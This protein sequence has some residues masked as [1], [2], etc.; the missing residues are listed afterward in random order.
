MGNSKIFKAAALLS[1]CFVLTSPLNSFADLPR[2]AA[3]YYPATEAFNITPSF[4][5]YSSS[6]GIDNADIRSQDHNFAINMEYGVNSYLSVG[7]KLAYGENTITTTQY[8]SSYET[9]VN[10]KGMMDPELYLGSRYNFEKFRI[11]GN[12]IGHASV[13]SRQI[14]TTDETGNMANG[15]ASADAELAVDAPLGPIT[16]GALFGKTIWNDYRQVFD[17]N[18]NTKHQERGA[19]FEKYK[20]YFEMNSLGVIKPGMILSYRKTNPSYRL[21]ENTDQSVQ[22]D[23]EQRDTMAEIYGRLR[24]DSNLILK[25]TLTQIDSV[26]NPNELREQTNKTYGLNFGLTIKY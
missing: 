13:E 4:D 10:R 1:A 6:Y 18:T 5:Y 2:A 14:P 16:A 9:R 3:L 11:Y 23:G 22:L 7:A 8:Y 20:V 25:G 24:I 21:I 26:K 15:G 19:E 17:N 12:L